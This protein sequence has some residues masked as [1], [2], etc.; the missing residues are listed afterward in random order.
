[1]KPVQ[2]K[3]RP[4]GAS[5]ASRPGSSQVEPEP[6]DFPADVDPPA[7]EQDDMGIHDAPAG[8]Q[9]DIPELVREY[10]SLDE[11]KA[12]WDRL[13]E[14]HVRP[15]PG[16]FSH[17]NLVPQPNTQLFQDCPWV[18]FHDLVSAE[19]QAR[20]SVCRPHGSLEEASSTSGVPR[21]SH[22]TGS[23]DYRRRVPLQLASTKGFVLNDR[24]GKFMRLT[25][26]ETDA[27]HEVLTWGRQP[28]N[29]RV[30]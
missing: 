28:G 5:Q 11:Y 25:P 13:K 26:K 23:V 7:E 21:Y 15:V 22:I 9:D 18:P 2:R 10:P 17:N 29:N 8:I 30:C 12:R 14:Y 20:L 4:S 3:Q 19:A 1:M 6:E 16:E 27:L 24:S